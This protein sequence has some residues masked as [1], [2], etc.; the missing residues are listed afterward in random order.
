MTATEQFFVIPHTEMA[1]T[2]HTPQVRTVLERLFAAATQDQE[3]PR[4]RKPGLSWQTATAQERADASES[5]YMPIS[6]QCGD[7]L[8]TGFKTPLL[9]S[10]TTSSSHRPRLCP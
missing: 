7:L 1:N 5:T 4:W 8:Y 6:P 9:V 10:C 3:T 2:L